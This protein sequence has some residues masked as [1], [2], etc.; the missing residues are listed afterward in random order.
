MPASRRTTRLSLPVLPLPL[1]VLSGSLTGWTEPVRFRSDP[2]RNR[3]SPYGNPQKTA[4]ISLPGQPAGLCLRRD[5][6]ELYVAIPPNGVVIVIATG[7]MVISRS[8]AVGHYP[9]AVALA[10]EAGRLFVAHQFLDS[11]GV[12]DLT[13]SPPVMTDQIP[14]SREPTAMCLTADGRQLVVSNLL[15]RALPPI[16]N[17]WQV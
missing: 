6:S 3:G 7:E 10:E 4:A 12:V 13:S 8:I 16:P 17:W 11:V 9:V 15:P 14:V 1:A 5:G 2:A